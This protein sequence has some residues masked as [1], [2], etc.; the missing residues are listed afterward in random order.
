MHVTYITLDSVNE[1]VGRS[2]ILPVIKNLRARGVNIKL[3]SFEKEKVSSKLISEFD[4]IGVEWSHNQFGKNALIS[5]IKRTIK[6][7]QQITKTDIV[8]ARGDIPVFAALL[9]RKAPVLWDMRGLWSEQ[10]IVIGTSRFKTILF[11][12]LILL[13]RLML[14]QVDA[15]TTLSYSLNTYSLELYGNKP[16]I[17]ESVTT[18][19]DTR[20]FNIQ[21]KLPKILRIV[22]SGSYNDYYNLDLTK[23]LIICLRKKV[24]VEI[25]WL[26][27][28][29]STRENLGLGEEIIMNVDYSSMPK[30]LNEF[31]IGV[32]ICR[33]IPRVNLG[34]VPTKIGE[35]LACGR[36]VIVNQGLGDLDQ[37]LNTYKAG[38]VVEES[39]L[40]IA[41]D[42]ILRI[43][44]DENTPSNCRQLAMDYFDLEKG[45]SKYL[46]IYQSLLG[47]RTYINPEPK[48]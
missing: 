43:S 40:N 18:V 15:I 17:R 31:S 6:I 5:P 13:R 23:E 11:Q 38:V 29:E 10:R 25:F 28:K 22:F 19:V 45:V 8:H 48:S 33:N 14:N 44:Q 7:I 41:A 3:I 36:P 37:L 4:L 2:Q 21:S 9:S 46:Y 39:N 30:Y 20:H 34:V 1:G 16:N 12:F 27:P 32:A 35:F 47:A 42:E 24:K 26:K